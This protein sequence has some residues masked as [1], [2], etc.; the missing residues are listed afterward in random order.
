MQTDAILV[1]NH[2]QAQGSGDGAAVALGPI[3]LTKLHPPPITPD[4][5]PRSHLLERLD[6]G[7]HPPA[8]SSRIASALLTTQAFLS[9]GE[10]ERLVVRVW[11]PPFGCGLGR[12]EMNRT[13][14][15]EAP[16]QSR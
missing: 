12:S 3:L 7:R 16:P 2:S 11:Q 1:D 15:P 13:G 9:R 6:K 5:L 14:T 4:L 8:T 10:V